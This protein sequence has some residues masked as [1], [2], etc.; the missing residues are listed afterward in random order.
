V[1]NHPHKFE[2]KEYS[3]WVEPQIT[4]SKIITEYP[5]FIIYAIHPKCPALGQYVRGPQFYCERKE[6]FS[7]IK[8]MSLKIPILEVSKNGKNWFE[9]QLQA[10][11]NKYN[12]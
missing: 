1:Y 9:E 10:L 8:A 5:E 3:L 2:Y 4:N 7:S 12:F 11:S 6:K